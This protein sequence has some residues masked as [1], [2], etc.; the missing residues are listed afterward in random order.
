ALADAIREGPVAGAPLA[1]F[2]EEPPPADH[3]LRALDQVIATPHLGAS[4]AEAQVNVAIAIAQQVAE[5]L[6]RGTIHNAVNA[7]SLSPEGLQGLRP[8]LTIAEK[9]GALA[10][11]LAPGAPQEISVQAAG[12][13]AERERKALSTA[14]LRGLLDRLI[15]HD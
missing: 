2:E 3:P 12:E 5:F 10:A 11:Q 7:P 14:V 15:D 4:T 13:V 1:V 8:Y 9:L 6:T